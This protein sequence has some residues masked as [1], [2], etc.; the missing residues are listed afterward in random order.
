M[1]P[2]MNVRCRSTQDKEYAVTATTSR[3][4]VLPLVSGPACCPNGLVEPL[5][6]DDAES[7]ATLL[8]AVSDPT[9]LQ[10]LALI[11]ATESGEACV[12]DLT[13]PLGLTQ[14]TVSHHLMVLTDAGLLRRE[15]R[16]TWAWYT[17]VPERLEQIAAIF[18]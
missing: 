14:P 7:L 1:F 12:C 8:K 11:R 10:L 4:S 5:E 18:R 17:V 2:P 9:R 16:A 6:R 13:A 3:R 15:K